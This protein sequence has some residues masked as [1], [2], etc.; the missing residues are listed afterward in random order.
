VN[1]FKI[2]R[3]RGDFMNKV[4][5]YY[6]ERRDKLISEHWSWGDWI[7]TDG[8]ETKT[9]A[10]ENFENKFNEF[11]KTFKM[12]QSG[13]LMGDEGYC[14]QYRIVDTNGIEIKW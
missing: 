8:F 14:F 13:A 9:K 4:T 10:K 1:I 6:I 5:R 7:Q 2:K 3:R 12:W 11:N